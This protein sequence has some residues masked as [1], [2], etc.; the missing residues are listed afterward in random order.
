MASTR[1]LQIDGEIHACM[2]ELGALGI[3]GGVALGAKA[4]DEALEILK[5][6]RGA[7]IPLDR[8]APQII[9]VVHQGLVFV[10][11]DALKL[12]I[13]GNDKFDK[14]TL[15]AARA[16]ATQLTRYLAF[17]PLI[18]MKTESDANAIIFNKSAA[19]IIGYATVFTS[20]KTPTIADLNTMFKAIGDNLKGIKGVDETYTTLLGAVGA[21]LSP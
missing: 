9:H 14:D 20:K 5:S 1:M 16:I 8:S 17:V 15:R 12:N 21:A 10:L 11:D 3:G 7:L 4:G 18:T 6:A 19:D 13:H 2:A